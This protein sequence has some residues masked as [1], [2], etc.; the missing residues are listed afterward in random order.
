MRHVWV[1]TFVSSVCTG[2]LSEMVGGGLRWGLFAGRAAAARFSINFKGRRGLMKT[3]GGVMAEVNILR[4]F[5][6]QICL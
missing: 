3:E 1:F 6:R 4:N 2:M 5:L